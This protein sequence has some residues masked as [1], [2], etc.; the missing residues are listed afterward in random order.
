[1]G[2]TYTTLRQSGWGLGHDGTEDGE[3]A[4]DSSEG[5][6][7]EGFVRDRVGVEDSLMVG[8]KSERGWS[9][10]WKKNLGQHV[11]EVKFRSKLGSW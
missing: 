5:L 2:E 1:M 3:G 10:D 4:D 9:F 6:H 11:K 8:R 7:F